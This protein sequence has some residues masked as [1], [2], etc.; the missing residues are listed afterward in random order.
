MKVCLIKEERGDYRSIIISIVEN[1]DAIS[2]CYCVLNVKL[3]EA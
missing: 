2:L 1:R 3:F